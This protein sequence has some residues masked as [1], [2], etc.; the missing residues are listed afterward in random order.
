MPTDGQTERV[1]VDGE[2]GRQ[3]G[4]AG[5]GRARRRADGRATGK[6]G[7]REVK[8]LLSK[9]GSCKLPAL[10]TVGKAAISASN[11][12]QSGCRFGGL[13]DGGWIGGMVGGSVRADA[14]A[15]TRPGG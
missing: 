10:G 6:R 8:D 9:P 11:P 12:R 2:T 5:W 13:S 4:R 7:Y 15:R 3:D 14:R 1:V